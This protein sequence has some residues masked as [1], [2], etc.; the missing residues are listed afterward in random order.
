MRLLRTKQVIAMTG[1]SRMTIYR[2]ERAGLF[3]TRRQLSRNLVGWKEDDIQAWIESR[4]AG[5]SD[6]RNG[7]AQLGLFPTAPL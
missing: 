6:R 7:Q 4:P 1:L 5:F 3:P 2:L